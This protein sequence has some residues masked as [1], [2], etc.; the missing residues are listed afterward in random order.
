M[1]ANRPPAPGGLG[2][3]AKRDPD[4]LTAAPSLSVHDAA[5]EHPASIAFIALPVRE[6]ETD[7]LVRGRATMSARRSPRG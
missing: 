5:E 2:I 1:L 7:H 4:D 3:P 6:K